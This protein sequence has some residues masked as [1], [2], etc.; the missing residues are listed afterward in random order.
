MKNEEI[1]CYCSNVTKDQIIKAMEQGARTLNDIRKMTGA[2]TLHR[3]KELSPKRD[4]MFFRYSRSDGRI[5]VRGKE[6][7]E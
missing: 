4:M 2:C 3:C 7:R 6:E 5:Y 1:I